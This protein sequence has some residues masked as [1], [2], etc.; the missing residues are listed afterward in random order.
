[1]LV[2]LPGIVTL[3][4]PLP[5]N[6]PSPDGGDAVGD[7]HAGQAGAWANAPSPDASDTVADG[8]A[9]Q[10]GAE[11][12]HRIPD[13]GDAAGNHVTL[14]RLVSNVI[15]RILVPMLVT[16]RPLIT[17]GWNG[18]NSREARRKRR[19]CCTAA[20]AAVGA[21]SVDAAVGIGAVSVLAGL[22]HSRQWEQQHSRL[23]DEQDFEFWFS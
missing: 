6:A 7:C 21:V 3:V 10:T 1:M 20:H 18:H 19:C 13:A 4:M 8:H 9:R 14:V 12:K 23:R 5:T 11:F 16:V 2:T 17:V 15:E 22:H